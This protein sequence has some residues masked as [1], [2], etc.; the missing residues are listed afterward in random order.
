MRLENKSFDEDAKK[1]GLKFADGLS[2]EKKT[3]KFQFFDSFNVN[4]DWFFKK[5]NWPKRSYNRRNEKK[6][7]L[8]S[9]SCLMLLIIKLTNP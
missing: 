3:V 8:T 9:S 6:Y 4:W 7:S 2:H 1:I 5:Q